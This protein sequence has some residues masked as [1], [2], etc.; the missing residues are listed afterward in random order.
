MTSFS[1]S[2]AAPLRSPKRCRPFLVISRW[3]SVAVP[4]NRCSGLTQALTS[5]RWQAKISSG[6]SMPVAIWRAYLWAAIPFRWERA[7]QPYP[8]CV[9]CP[10]QSQQLP[11]PKPEVLLTYFKKRSST[12]ELK[13]RCLGLT[14]KLFEQVCLTLLP[15]GIS[16]KVSIYA[17]LIA[18]ALKPLLYGLNLGVPLTTEPFQSQQISSDPITANF[19]NLWQVFS[20]KFKL[21]ITF[22]IPIKGV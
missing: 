18:C 12:S 4:Q 19:Q 21:M 2:T 11:I 20:S 3:L 1:V 6:C 16:P 13:T 22:L 9:T 5:H 17:D 7:N 10:V 15:F 14:H 8:A